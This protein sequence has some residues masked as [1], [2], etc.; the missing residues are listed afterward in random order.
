[1]GGKIT[2]EKKVYEFSWSGIL[3]FAI[4]APLISLGIYYSNDYVWLHGITSR[5]TVWSLNLITGLNNYTVYD[6]NHYWG[7]AWYIY[8]ENTAR[9]GYLP[10]IQF[11]TFCTGIQAVAIFV[12]VILP[13]PHSKDAATSKDIWPRKIV[14]S[15]LC[16]LLFYFVNIVRM[17][18]QLYLYHVGYQWDD[19]HYSISA[20]SSF[21]AIPAVLVLHKYV[22]EFIMSI[23][24]AMDQVREKIKQARGI[25]TQKTVDNED[26]NK[27]KP[28]ES[29]DN[30]S[31]VENPLSPDDVRPN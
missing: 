6:P 9:T 7:A 3:L 28:V 27:E 15:V 18:L 21:I 12:G 11:T 2:Y 14:A 13:V 29:P 16:S 19:I 23:I 24:W 30:Q 17:W 26:K 4:L 31:I 25:P 1:M 22:P 5:L 8:I 10:A 20:A